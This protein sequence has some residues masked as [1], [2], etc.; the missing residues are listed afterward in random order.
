MKRLRLI[1]DFVRFSVIEKISFFQKVIS[2][3]TNNPTFP[4]PDVSLDAA[5]ILVNQLQKDYIAAVISNFTVPKIS[6][7]KVPV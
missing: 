7:R 2:N 4:T 3:M 1:L 5:T 6:N